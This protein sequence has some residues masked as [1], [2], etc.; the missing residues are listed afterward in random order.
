[1]VIWLLQGEL[2]P[3]QKRSE[4]PT[5]VQS[6]KLFT[7][8]RRSQENLSRFRI[9]FLEKSGVEIFNLHR[10]AQCL[11]P[12]FRIGSWN[13]LEEG[14]GRQPGFNLELAGRKLRL[15]V[16]EPPLLW[17]VRRSPCEWT[18]SEYL[19][20][21]SWQ[22]WVWREGGDLSKEE[23][24]DGTGTEPEGLGQLTCRIFIFRG[25]TLELESGTRENH[26]IHS[27]VWQYFPSRL[28][29]FIFRCC[30]GGNQVF[31]SCL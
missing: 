17:W 15:L 24:A 30:F 18:A 19:G 27:L 29:G 4:L 16:S 21:C 5:I 3:W 13:L 9:C 14:G 28:F 7:W 1:M 11:P 22:H 23:P 26:D 20:D 6:L 12:E 8:G 25:R 2:A 31:C 10:I